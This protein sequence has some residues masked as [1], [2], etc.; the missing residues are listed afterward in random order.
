[1]SPLKIPVDMHPGQRGGPLTW[2]FHQPL[3]YYTKLL[4]AHGFVI[5]ALEEWTSDKESTGK[6]RHMENRS[7]SEFPLFLAIRAIANFR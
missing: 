3:E 7:R 1:M 2:S 6:A 4:A 5:T